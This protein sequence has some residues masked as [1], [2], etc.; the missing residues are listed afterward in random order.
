MAIHDAR[1]LTDAHGFAVIQ[2]EDDEC[3]RELE[4]AL[5][6]DEPVDDLIDQLRC[7]WAKYMQSDE[8][9]SVP[10]VAGHRPAVRGVR[11]IRQVIAEM[12]GNPDAGYRDFWYC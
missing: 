3:R 12:H 8:V 4:T 11:S 1:V 2:W 7:A 5:E 10:H 9:R 6:L